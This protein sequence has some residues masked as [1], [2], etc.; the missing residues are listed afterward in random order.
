MNVE[1]AV[2]FFKKAAKWGHPGAQFEL[3]DFYLTGKGLPKN[4]TKGVKW[5]KQSAENGHKEAQRKLS[6]VTERTKV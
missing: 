5:L 2:T 6:V 4:E 3:G 1:K